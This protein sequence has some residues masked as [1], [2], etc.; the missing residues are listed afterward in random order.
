MM[1]TVIEKCM[2]RLKKM[3]SDSCVFMKR[4][5]KEVLYLTHFSSA[6]VSLR[7]KLLEEER[8]AGVITDGAK[9]WKV[10]GLTL[11]IPQGDFRISSP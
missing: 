7:N 2:M 10:G 9:A 6:N 4:Q 3:A 5:K 1:N 8:V 11:V